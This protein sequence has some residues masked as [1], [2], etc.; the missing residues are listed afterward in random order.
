MNDCRK[1][2]DSDN[3]I[4]LMSKTYSDLDEVFNANYLVNSKLANHNFNKDK[5][6]IKGFK[7]QPIKEMGLVY[8]NLTNNVKTEKDL[9]LKNKK[10][11]QKSN[12]IAVELEKKYEELDFKYL[13]KKVEGSKVKTINLYSPSSNK[14]DE[15]LNKKE[16]V[17]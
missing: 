11:L 16:K 14:S 9:Y 3:F 12:P 4:K 15:K 8:K 2:N 17:S 10:L 5:K 13:K 1:S 6:Q 7:F